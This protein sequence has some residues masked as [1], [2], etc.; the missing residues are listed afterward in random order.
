[1]K[2]YCLGLMMLMTGLIATAQDF[3]YVNEI[4][5]EDKAQY[6]EAKEAAMECCCYLTAVRYDKKDEQRTI[7][8]TYVKQWLETL[9]SQD[10]LLQNVFEEQESLLEMYMAYYAMNYLDEEGEAAVTELQAAALEGV[11]A[12]CSI[13]TN[14]LKMTKEL[15]EISKL[16][17]SGELEQ[18]IINSTL[19]SSVD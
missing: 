3:S 10:I 15:K 18:S 19:T 12:Y 7:A 16:I 11:V 8:A 1:M 17:E 9:D 4:D 6:E 13:P 14:K 5:L 2:N